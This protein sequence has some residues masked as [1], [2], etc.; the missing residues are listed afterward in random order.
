MM[1]VQI[2]DASGLCNANCDHAA[3]AP[4]EIAVCVAWLRT[5][6]RPIKTISR[7]F[8]SYALKHLVERDSIRPGVAYAMTDRHGRP[9]QH[10][11]RYVSN[12]AFLTAAR[13]EGYRLQ[14][15]GFSSPNA[16]LNISLPRGHLRRR[17]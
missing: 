5:Y 8:G 14:P 2:D 12:G 16:W 1:A 11:A 17:A 4:E 6:A 10:C 9:W 15:R 7:R 13:V 3:P